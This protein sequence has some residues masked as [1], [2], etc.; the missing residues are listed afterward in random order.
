MAADTYPTFSSFRE[1]RMKLRR[2]SLLWIMAAGAAVTAVTPVCSADSGTGP[3]S[4]SF[5]GN[6][7]GS[8]THGD[9]PSV[10]V[11]LLQVTFFLI[12]IIGFFFLIMKVMAKK[13]RQWMQGRAVKTL[14]GAALGPNKSLQVVEIG[15]SIY[16][17]GVGDNVRLIDKIDD[18]EKA[19]QLMAMFTAAPAGEPALAQLGKWLTRFRRDG[20][21]KE[22][23]AEEDNLASGA[24]QEVLQSKI[25]AMAN[26]RQT[27]E[28]LLS[29]SPYTDRSS[30]K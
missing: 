3:N 9:A 23:P 24:F 11:M 10:F 15:R 19:E 12:L 16:I 30:K 27:V 18:P 25:K 21:G 29:Q 28:D 2:K 22:E 13:N 20:T 4:D 26:R 8:I 7:G 6:A 5:A 17:I 1:G 14:G